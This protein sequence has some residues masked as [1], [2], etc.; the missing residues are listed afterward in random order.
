M[1]L[2]YLQIFVYAGTPYQRAAVVTFVPPSVPL[3]HL[4]CRVAECD[5]CVCIDKKYIYI[6]FPIKVPKLLPIDFGL[7]RLKLVKNTEITQ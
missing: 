1:G 3:C 7:N 5:L 4:F 6:Y 2:E